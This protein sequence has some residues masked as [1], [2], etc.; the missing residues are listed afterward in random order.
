MITITRRAAL[1]AL[2]AAPTVVMASPARPADDEWTRLRHFLEN[3]SPAELMNYH[4]MQAAD[5]A[6]EISGST[7][8]VRHG[9]DDG[10]MML[11]DYGHCQTRREDEEAAS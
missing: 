6:S 2:T 5:A 3:A 8:M 10:L 7:W 1:A 11:V 4:L 9:I